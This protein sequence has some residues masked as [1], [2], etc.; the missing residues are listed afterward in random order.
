MELSKRCFIRQLK[1]FPGKAPSFWDNKENVLQFLEE[2]KEQYNLKTFEDWNLLKQRQIRDMKGGNTILNKLTTYDLKCLGFPE[3]KELFIK[4]KPKPG[5]KPKG[6]WNFERN[7]INFLKEIKEK[8]KLEIFEDWNSLTQ[9]QIQSLDGGFALLNKHTIYELKCLGFPEGKEL[10]IEEKPQ[11]YWNRKEN[12]QLFLKSIKE[13]FSLQTANDWNLI[14][15]KHIQSIN[16]GATLLQNYTLYQLKCLGFP[17]GKHE[18]DE[19]NSLKPSGYWDDKNNVL[20]FLKDIK[21]KFN[22]ETFEDWDLLKQKQ[23]QSV[24]GGFALLNK[25][26]MY[27]L[28]CMGFPD[29]KFEKPILPKPNYKPPG[30]WNDKQ[31]RLEFLEQLKS[32]FNLKTPSD[33]E[34]LSVCQIKSIGGNWLFKD[35]QYL[36]K[37][38]E[39]FKIT[40]KENEIEYVTYSLHDL[41]VSNNK[42]S[43]KSSQRWLFL[44][45]Q[46]LFPQEEI[47]EDYFH[48]EIS[49]ESGKTIQFDIFL[50]NRNIAIE[51]HGE[52]HFNDISAFGS[53]ENYKARDKEKE[54]LCKKYNVQLI[55]IPYWW[56]NH[57]D[58]LRETLNS[59]IKL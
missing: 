6:Y 35:K 23:I 34:R 11:G 41:L 28:K 3:G 55:I 47:V 18:F 27:D 5:K 37:S 2:T 20:Q 58:S 36:K 16:G 44:Q 21:E 29:G 12:I 31:N 40:N 50:L 14:T 25:Y 7:I 43:K 51:Y 8:Y 9:K 54:I 52:Q 59:A 19:P 17:E 53:L 46:K 33:W 4:H 56:D 24:D 15:Q 26:T 30:Y 10:F 45:V 48:S 38:K 13:K 42:I 32:K 49:R 1:S 57:L 39:T 22:L